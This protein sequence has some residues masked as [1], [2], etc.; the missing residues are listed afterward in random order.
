MLNDIEHINGIDHFVKSTVG[1]IEMQKRTIG[2]K[3]GSALIIFD[4]IWVPIDG[5]KMADA[6]RHD[7]RTDTIAAADFQNPLFSL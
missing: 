3:F 5:V 6:A 7:R 4:N 2:K 1:N